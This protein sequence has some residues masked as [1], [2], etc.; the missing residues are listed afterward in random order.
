VIYVKTVDKLKIIIPFVPLILAAVILIIKPYYLFSL[1]GDTNFHLARAREILESPLSRLFWDNITYYPTGRPLWHQPLF[2]AVY[3]FVWYVGGVRFAQSFM[4]ILQVLLTVGVASWIANKE[5]GTVAGFFAGFFAF[6]VPAPST[7]IAAIPAT[8]V[9]IL[10][11]LTIYYIPKD[12]KKAFVTSLLALWTHIVTLVSFIPLFIVDNYKDKTNQKIILLLIPSWLFWVGY[13]IYFSNRLVTGGIFYSFA[14]PKFI[15]V[16]PAS[17][18]F[19]I[20]L[21]ILLLGMIGI[22]ILYKINNKQFKLYLTYI[23][24]VVGFSL[25]GFNGDFLRSL[26]FIALPLAILSG[27]TVQSGYNHISKN[28]RPILS[29]IFLLMFLSLSMLGVTIFSAELPNQQ[30]IGW[31]ALNYPFEGEYAPVKYYIDNNTNKNDVVWAQNDLTEK[32]AWMTGRKVSNGMYPDGVYGATRGFVDQHQ[33]INIYQSGE[34]VLIN[35][36]NNRTIEQ[37]KV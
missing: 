1:G 10:A 19:L 24:T 31:N 34:Y 22:Y 13:W 27:L 25:F 29:S 3:A 20:F 5:Y 9:P 18:A 15:S 30:E 26:E 23:L 28:H 17:A 37:I 21:S 32:I 8:Y 7:L 4:C 16:Y 35:D 14:H 2:N 12:K 11:V 6:F 33:K 36:F